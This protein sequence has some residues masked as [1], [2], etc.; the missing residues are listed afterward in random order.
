MLTPLDRRP[1]PRKDPSPAADSIGGGGAAGQ[2]P[3]AE[4]GEGKQGEP[5]GL[6]SRLLG[7]LVP[8]GEEEEEEIPPPSLSVQLVDSLGREAQVLLHEYGPVRYPIEIRIQRRDDQTFAGNTEMVLQSFSIPL[9]DF[10]QPG[11]GSLDLLHLKEIR[12]VFDQDVSGTVVLDEI[13]FADMD[14]AFLPVSGG[15]R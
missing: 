7:W 1:G 10:L 2:K 11:P 15:S 5:K 14:P 3:G 4:G 13:G 9:R 6:L 8:L 12:L